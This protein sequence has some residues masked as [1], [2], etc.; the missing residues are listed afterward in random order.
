MTFRDTFERYRTG[1]ATE[2]ECRLVEEELEKNQLISEYLDESWENAD[3][4]TR[5]GDVTAVAGLS[6]NAAQPVNGTLPGGTGQVDDMKKIRKALRHRSLRIILTTLG[7]CVFLLLV[8]ALGIVPAAEKQY[9]TPET[10]RFGVEFGSDLELALAAYSELFV[11]GQTIADIASS[12]S[13]FASYELSISAMDTAT[14]DSFYSYGS[15]QKGRL[16]LS[17]DLI[18]PGA[19]NIFDNADAGSSR[20]EED[21]QQQIC[22]KLSALPDFVQVEAAVSFSQDLTMEELLRFKDGLEEGDLQWIGIRS[23]SKNQQRLPL[24]G[25]APFTGGILYQEINETYPLFEIKGQV[26]SGKDLETHFKS[27]LRFSTDMREEG[28][29]IVG[30]D[31]AAFSY[32]YE[33]VLN[34]VEEN[35]VYAYGC[36]LAAPAQVF[37]DLLDR[38]VVSQVWPQDGWINV[39]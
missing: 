4:I 27:L 19:M 21:I 13:G 5:P 1:T 34:Y 26:P 11:P 30:T 8:V 39:M 38:G 16:T 17:S 18:T 15:L 14:G 9:L 29:E 37:L 35:G 31:S 22:E 20:L 28:F 23:C 33:E 3:D 24:I 36:Y 12:R 6:D 25:I 2:E 10:N 7:L 32:D